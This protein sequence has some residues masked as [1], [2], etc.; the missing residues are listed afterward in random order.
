MLSDVC[1]PFRVPCSSVCHGAISRTPSCHQWPLWKVDIPIKNTLDTLEYKYVKV[2][3][4]GSIGQWEPVE[5]RLLGLQEFNGSAL[6]LQDGDFGRKHYE[7]SSAALLAATAA[8]EVRTNKSPRG[9]SIEFFLVCVRALPQRACSR[10][11]RS[12]E[13]SRRGR[14]ELQGR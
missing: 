4:D 8:A 7:S 3:E 5:N 1:L 13:S 9:P 14:V 6:V 2:R 12:S 10:K 11:C